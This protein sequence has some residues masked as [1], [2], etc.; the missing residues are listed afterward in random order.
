MIIFISDI[1]NYLRTRRNSLF[2]KRQRRFIHTLKGTYR[3]ML[4]LWNVTSHYKYLSNGFLKEK[5]ICSKTIY[6]NDK[7]AI[8]LFFWYIIS[9]TFIIERH[10]DTCLCKIKHH[11][12]PT[13]IRSGSKPLQMISWWKLYGN[14]IQPLSDSTL[15][16]SETPVYYTNYHYSYL[17]MKCLPSFLFKNFMDHLLSAIKS[18][19]R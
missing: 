16:I 1:R 10:T 3:F 12:L 13:M 14:I 6:D 11:K 18:F 17:S 2:P 5:T 19:E 9:V 4:F 8:A 7:A 15:V